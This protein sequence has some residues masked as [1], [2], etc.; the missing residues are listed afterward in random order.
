[1]VCNPVT[2][3]VF[4]IP[5]WHAAATCPFCREQRAVSHFDLKHANR[6]IDGSAE[7]TCMSCE[8]KRGKKLDF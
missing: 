6:P 1:M 5:D 8:T 3:K 2:P 7:L 4:H